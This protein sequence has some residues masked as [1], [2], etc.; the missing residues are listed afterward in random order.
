MPRQMFIDLIQQD[1]ECDSGL[2][3]MNFLAGLDIEIA[4]GDVRLAAAC[5]LAPPMP[6]MVVRSVGSHF[7]Q[8]SQNP[9]RVLESE[10][11]K[12]PAIV[13]PEFEVCDLDQVL[14]QRPGRLA[15]Q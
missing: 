10:I 14:H 4:G 6:E 9:V 2:A 15:P 8:V 3:A 13:F 11:P 7:L 5:R 12:K 1:L